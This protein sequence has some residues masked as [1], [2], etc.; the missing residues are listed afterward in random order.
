M[1]GERDDTEAYIHMPIL[2]CYITTE[3]DALLDRI[4]EETFRDKEELAE[5]AI[6]EAINEYFRKARKEPV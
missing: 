5:A 6:S 4:A 1:D 2:R 3:D